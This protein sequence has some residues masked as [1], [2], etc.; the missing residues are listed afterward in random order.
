[1]EPRISI[2]SPILLG[3]EMGYVLEAVEKVQLSW[4]GEFV[5]RFE[6]DFARFCGVE[7][8]ATCC[9]GTAALHLA[10]LALGIGP[11]DDVFLPALTYVATANAV[12]YVGA[13]PVFCDVN[14]KTWCLDPNEVESA[15]RK[16][17]RPACILPVHL[18]GVPAQMDVLVD[19]ANHYDVKIVEDAAE[20]HGAI[21]GGN[22][23][24][25]M[26]DIGVFSF[27]ANKLLTT[28]EGGMLTTNDQELIERIRL[29][30]G[31]GE[32][33]GRKFIHEVVGYNYRMT[34]LQAAVGVAQ[35][36]TFER[37][38]A[39]HSRV[40]RA[41]FNVLR[42]S[43]FELQDAPT[44][45][46]YTPWLFSVLLPEHVDRDDVIYK[47]D[48]VGVETRP[49][50]PPTTTFS[51]YARDTPPH[52]L[53]IA[54]RGISLPTHGDLTQRDINRVVSELKEAVAR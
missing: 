26:G 22:R 3:K 41:Y 48:R 46:T 16:S 24:G 49:V 43:E 8:A 50:F 23:T 38:L 10:L 19:L 2:S 5:G 36:E 35:L 28:G 37:H 34:N 17:S 21:F 45:V 40:G 32:T 18:Y 4:H 27:F 1:M 13:N 20:A 11:G 9:N 53:E 6:R 54:R 31:Q 30:R 44:G 33:P 25:S 52:T 47:L 51:M 7:F 14:R 29:Y 12:H 42:D 15:I 39:A